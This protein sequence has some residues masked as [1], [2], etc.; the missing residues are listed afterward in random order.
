MRQKKQWEQVGQDIHGNQRFEFFGYFVSLSADGSTLGVG[1]PQNNQTG[2]DTGAARVYRYDLQTKLWNKIGDDLIGKGQFDRFGESISVSDNGS[3]VIVGAIKNDDNGKD[4]GHAR[5]FTYNMQ[6][7]IWDQRGNDIA[8]E[9]AKDFAGI[10]VDVS[11][12]GGIVAV[13][14]D[15]NDGSE[16]QSGHVRVYVYVSNSNE[17]KK[18]GQ[19][20]DGEAGG[21][22]FGSALSLSM[23]GKTIAVGA[24][25][26]RGNGDNSGHARVLKY[27][28][29]KNVWVQK[30]QDID[31]EAIGDNS[32]VSVSLS[33]NGNIVAVGAKRNDGS[34]V[35]SG[36]ARVYQ[37]VARI[38]MWHQIGYDIDGVAKGDFFGRSVSLSGDGDIVAVG[39]PDHDD[40]K[41][42]SFGHVRVFEFQ[43]IVI[44][45]SVDLGDPVCDPDQTPFRLEFAMDL[46][47][48][49]ITWG[50]F[51]EKGNQIV[52]ENFAESK[53]KYKSGERVTRREC[54]Q[55]NVLVAFL[56]SDEYGDGLCCNW[57][58]GSFAVNYG[59]SLI[60]DSLDFQDV[61]ALCLPQSQQYTPV[62]ID[63]TLDNSP[64][65]TWWIL[66]DS[67]NKTELTR[68]QTNYQGYDPYSSIKQALCARVDHCLTYIIG[69]N[70]VDDKGFN[71]LGIGAGYA[72]SLGGQ[73]L[74]PKTGDFEATDIVRFGNSCEIPD[75]KSLVQIV[76]YAG[77]LARDVSWQLT[78]MDNSKDSILLDSGNYNVTF[79]GHFYETMV[80]SDSCLTFRMHGGSDASFTIRWNGNITHHEHR[81]FNPL[82][83]V[84]F[85][86]CSSC[87][88]GTKLAQVLM[89][90][91]DESTREALWQIT[92]SSGNSLA[93]G[94]DYK[95]YI[96]VFYDEVC[97]SSSDCLSLNIKAQ[98]DVLYEL[99]WDGKLVKYDTPI[100]D[101]SV[102]FGTC[103]SC[104]D[105]QSLFQLVL[106]TGWQPA[107]LAW[108]VVN[109][110]GATI[111]IKK[112]NSYDQ[113][114]QF[115]HE[116]H[117][118]CMPSNDC[119]N[120]TI[121]DLC[122]EACLKYR[123]LWNETLVE[124]GGTSF[125][126]KPFLRVGGNCT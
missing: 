28:G 122:A 50:I 75:G 70:N 103:N 25:V 73:Y 110:A 119:L 8:G 31:G 89:H 6:T 71:G 49:D 100:S 22:L 58:K 37:Y 29:S 76:F 118:R 105:G 4:S 72:L 41:G 17:W 32:G 35:D 48:E 55:K 18:L 92:D 3:V 66:H 94:G 78:S 113:T 15:F 61:R 23:D 7:K 24:T 52:F 125:E 107:K 2:F 33:R 95:E 62:S 64:V 79:S 102:K 57:G 85:G 60:S 39:S 36:H 5:V 99:I 9:A 120:V 65:Q 53:K 114:Y 20:I 117:E 47:P 123:I 106:N 124:E 98:D 87:N 83:I 69:D 90:K 116:Y 51:N 43:P 104:P 97:V 109:K 86:S 81:G 13:G 38:N 112:E 68:S 30:G 91:K 14:A 126:K 93:D 82:S 84:R 42:T 111:F 21:D 27:D 40:V 12:D 44:D 59:G 1:A 67:T 77:F 121:D 96:E 115:K 56:I 19:D 54:L 45:S 88:E 26:N 10:F 101:V 108:N 11:G 80:P 63:L 34:A 16:I 46:F 74:K